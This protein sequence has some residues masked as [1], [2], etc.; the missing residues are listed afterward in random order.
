MGGK[1][2]LKRFIRGDKAGTVR[3]QDAERVH[4]DSLSHAALAEELRRHVGHCAEAL[5]RDMSGMLVQ[6]LAQPEVCQ[7]ANM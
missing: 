4:V 5:S 7:P 2:N 1:G 6:N 3:T